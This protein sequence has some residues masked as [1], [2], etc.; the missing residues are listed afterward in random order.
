[1]LNTNF[2]IWPMAVFLCTMALA[3]SCSSK[4]TT[5]TLT[6]DQKN[7]LVGGSRINQCMEWTLTS[8]QSADAASACQG[9]GGVV[10]F[11]PCRSGGALGTCDGAMV[12]GITAKI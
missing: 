12:N 11:E 9:I 8:S 4:S 2:R 7:V 6:C 10:S 5:S 3:L 1:M